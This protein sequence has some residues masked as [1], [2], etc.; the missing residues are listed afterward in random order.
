MKRQLVLVVHNVRSCH[1]IGS[2]LRSADAFAASEVILTGFSPYPKT[3]DDVRLPHIASVTDRKIAKTALG[4]EKSV[5]W[6]HQA[7]IHT[8]LD[9]LASRGYSLAALEQTEQALALNEAILPAKLAIIVGREVDGIEPEILKQADY[10]IE[11][12]M[13]GQK[14]S[15]NVAVAAAIAMYAA[16]FS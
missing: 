4:A 13:L 9:E 16:R 10:H 7:D 15:L 2:I 8:V 14:E 6:R 1:N 5:T 3:K 12:P 11:I